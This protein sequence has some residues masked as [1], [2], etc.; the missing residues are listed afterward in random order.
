MLSHGQVGPAEAPCPLQGAPV[1]GED[2]LLTAKGY[3]SGLQAQGYAGGGG[4]GVLGE[5][6][7]GDDGRT[8]SNQIVFRGVA[9]VGETSHGEGEGGVD[10]VLRHTV[11]LV[12]DE[13]LLEAQHGGGVEGLCLVGVVADQDGQVAGGLPVH[14]VL[15]AQVQGEGAG[16][17][18]HH[19]GGEDA[20]VGQAHGILLH[21]VEHA[22]DADEVAGLV[23]EPLVGPQ[24]LENED[25]HGGEEAVGAD[26]DQEHRHEVKGDG[27]HAVGGTQGDVVAGPQGENSQEG[28]EPLGPGLPLPHLAAVEELNG[29]GDP[30]L[31]QVGQQG[32]ADEDAEE[33]SGAGHGVPG[34]GEAEG[35]G[36]AQELVEGQGHQL[37]E[38]ETGQKAADDPGP[39]HEQRLEE[40]HRGDVALAHA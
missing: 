37:V 9:A 18:D 35:H 23:V 14:D 1:D 16:D 5:D 30:D 17:H 40:E 28:H 3:L 29:F 34:D 32:Q 11:P 22:G 39:A 36:E 2:V 13:A 8:Q 4:V 38:E 7:D 25:A 21:A 15:G 33:D 10:Q 26:D 31:V 12:L 24:G 6:L 27:L 19:H 20:D